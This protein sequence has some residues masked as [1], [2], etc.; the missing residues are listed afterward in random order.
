[1]FEEERKS[2]KDL[3]MAHV[4]LAPKGLC[5]R[6]EIPL[7]YPQKTIRSWTLDRYMDYGAKF[8]SVD[9][10]NTF[11]FAINFFHNHYI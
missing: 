2:I 3:S 11:C 10:R 4:V 7:D 5:I 9:N 1:M 8:K 6:Y